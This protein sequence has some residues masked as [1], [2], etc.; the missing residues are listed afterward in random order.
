MKTSETLGRRAVLTGIGGLAAARTLGVGSV[1]AL[2]PYEEVAQ[3]FPEEQTIDFG[4]AV[5]VDGDT[6]LVGSPVRGVGGTVLTGVVYVYGR[7]RQGWALET[8]LSRADA[9]R[10]LRFGDAVA[11]DGD[12]AV[13]AVRG[14]TESTPTA[15]G[16]FVYE[17]RHGEWQETARLLVEN[18]TSVAEF[19]ID[20]AVD[21]RYAAVSVLGSDDD[22]PGGVYVYERRG[23][24]WHGPTR[25]RPATGIEGTNFGRSVDIDGR[26]LVVAA[27]TANAAYLFERRGRRWVEGATL[28]LPDT[29]LVPFGMDV[30][31]AGRN[32]L[33]GVGEAPL[34]G[35]GSGAVYAFRRVGRNWELTETLTRPGAASGDR[36][37]ER[38]ATDGRLT[39]VGA[40]GTDGAGESA[41][42]AYLY[43]LARSGWR[44]RQS[45]TASDAAAGDNFG[46][47][48][49]LDRRT[50][51]IGAWRAVGPNG[52]GRGSV[53]AFE[54]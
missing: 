40:I 50:L 39:L 16:G 9:V 29:G 46:S 30:A 11:L 1:T 28:T 27:P 51:G 48:V 49:S 19:L 21:G 8:K 45:F 38:V 23:S 26:R 42:S 2:R 33:V 32:V 5:A 18:D 3:F 15:T 4:T 52:E 53:Y 44:L 41:G 7:G 36:F 35:Q 17:R 6:M 20:A 12:T 47:T 24:G 13:V 10:G 14:G 31:I 22:G 43:E 34:N 37:G 25:L 54:R